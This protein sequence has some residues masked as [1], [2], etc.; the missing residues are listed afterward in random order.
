[1]TPVIFTR[2]HRNHLIFTRNHTA[3]DW[4]GKLNSRLDN[5]LSTP[6]LARLYFMG[7]MGAGSAPQSRSTRKP[8]QA[9]LLDKQ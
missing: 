2:Y 8:L 3:A 1:M 9:L 7:R 4:V 5:L 6:Q